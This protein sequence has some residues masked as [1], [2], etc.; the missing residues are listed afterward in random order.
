MFVESYRQKTFLVEDANTLLR[1]SDDLNSVVTD[2]GT[3]KTIPAGTTIKVAE[4][5]TT[6]AGSK[7]VNIFVLAMSEDGASEFGW[8]SAKNLKG[9]FLSET[10]GTIEPESGASRYGPNA[11]W[12]NG[13]YI[14]QVTLIRIVG[15]NREIEHIAEQTS[16]AF[17][18]MVDAAQGAGRI[19]GLNSGFR[20]YPDQKMLSDGWK[21][22]L[23]GFNP[24]NPPGYSNHQNGVAFDIDVGV[25]PGNPVYDWLARNAT[26]FG[27]V[28]TVPREVWH[29]EYLPEKAEAARNRGSHEAYQ[30]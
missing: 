4:A 20:S 14:E 11:T 29:W 3:P 12:S 27:F 2:N 6:P 26:Q 16:E 24:A 23:P 28:R 30:R 1:K 25:G 10:L 19:I 8:T 18:G 15:T 7:A 13:N 21:R 17:L 22:R 5:R 9:Q